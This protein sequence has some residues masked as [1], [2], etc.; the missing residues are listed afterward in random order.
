[1]GRL[2][3]AAG[4]VPGAGAR[5]QGLE[6]GRVAVDVTRRLVRELAGRGVDV[7]HVPDNLDLGP[8][9]R[10]INERW[11]PGDRAL[12]LH[13]NAAASMTAEGSLVA[14]TQASLP[15]ARRLV[16]ALVSVGIKAWGKGV[17]HETEIAHMRG[18]RHLG[19]PAQIPNAALLEL[20]FITNAHD[21]AYF[22]DQRQ[23]DRLVDALGRALTPAQ[24]R[25]RLYRYAIRAPRST[26]QAVKRFLRERKREGVKR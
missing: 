15:W 11:Q 4:H 3:V 23:L 6:E 26:I 22:Q 5:G 19:F 20:G 18:W 1:M 12:E 21:A 8:T 9:I 7:I 14:Y 24:P 17:Y 16:D 10:F 2:F 13:L 25:P